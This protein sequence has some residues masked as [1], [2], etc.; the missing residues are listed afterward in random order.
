MKEACYYLR[1]YVRTSWNCPTF[2]TLCWHDWSTWLSRFPGRCQENHRS[3]YS[4][5]CSYMAKSSVCLEHPWTCWAGKSCGKQSSWDASW[6]RIC[7]CSSIKSLC[8][9]WYVECCWK[10]KKRDER[11]KI[12]SRKILVL[13]GFK[14]VDQFI[15]LWLMIPHILKVKKYMRSQ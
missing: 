10:I 11:K 9:S 3:Y 6:K 4:I 1:L 15:T 2:R 13:A 8:F 12:L 14:L 5:W 7:L